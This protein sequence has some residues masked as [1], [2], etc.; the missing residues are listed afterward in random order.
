M[1]TLLER[2]VESHSFRFVKGYEMIR[3]EE[4]EKRAEELLQPICTAQ[5]LELVDVEYVK[6]GATRYLRAYLDKPGGIKI[7]DCEAASRA[8]E[9]EL[10]RADFI[11]EAYTLEVSSPGLLR[12]FKKDRDYQRNIGN[13]VELHLFKPD[14]DK[15]KE[16]I[17]MLE[18][19]DSDTVTLSFGEGDT[20]TFARRDVSLVRPYI[21]FSD[22]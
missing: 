15:N 16:Y 12:P 6:E 7:G 2:V 1:L 22:F 3:K 5:G 19:F 10:D 8:W 20:K 21:D 9:A 14:A 13:D 17:G 18:A 11:E 4:C